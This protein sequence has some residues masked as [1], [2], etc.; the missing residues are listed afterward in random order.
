MGSSSLNKTQKQ[1][2]FD[3][4]RQIWVKATP[5]E[6]VRQRWLG[7]M[8]G[9]LHYPKELL[10]V[11]KEL[12]EL[13]HLFSIDVPE[14]RVDILCYGKEIHPSF[15]LYPLL[16]M[17]CK[18][19]RL[20]DDTLSQLIGYNHHVKAYFAAAVSLDEVRLGTFDAAKKKY[21]FCSFLP[22]YKELIKWVKP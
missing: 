22:S 17:E 8:I 20:N 9:E 3:Q 4:V 19:E 13:P 16:L 10:T 12:K 11:E 6:K 14:R 1:L 5:E 21:V 2:I 15:P 7:L 18:D